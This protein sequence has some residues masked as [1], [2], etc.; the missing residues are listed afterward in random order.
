MI[1]L[2]PTETARLMKC[3]RTTIMRRLSEGE[4]KAYKN[5]GRWLIPKANIE[6]YLERRSNI[7]GVTDEQ[8]Q[9]IIHRQKIPTIRDVS[10]GKVVLHFAQR[11]ENNT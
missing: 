4:I 7:G 10:K 8:I 3:S 2:T 6:A 11:E 9:K 1:Y 5:G